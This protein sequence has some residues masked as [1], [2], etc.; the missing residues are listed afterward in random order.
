MQYNY[1]GKYSATTNY[2]KK[3]VVSYQTTTND[4]VKYYFCLTDHIN[5]LPTVSGD[6]AHWATVNTLSNFPNNVDTF[7]NHTNIQ[8]SDKSNVSRYQELILK[9]TLTSIE[10]D[11]LNTLTQTLRDK[12]ILPQDFNALQESI[13][14]MQMYLK[15][16]VEGYINQKQ[17]EMQSQIDKFTD[18]GDYSS[19]TTYQKNNFVTYNFET[20]IC[21]V[22]NTINILPTNPT[23]WRKAAARG[24]K[25]EKGDAGLNLVFK[26]SYDPLVSYVVGDAVEYQ[27]SVFYC[28][29]NITGETPSSNGTSWTIF[30]SR[31]S[32][33]VSNTAPTSP[34]DKQVWVDSSVGKFK[35]YDSATSSWKEVNKDDI[36]AINNKI[37]L[38]SGLETT[39]KSNLVGAT[40]EIKQTV[41]SHLADDVRHITAEERTEWDAKETPDGSRKKIEQTSYSK[42]KSNKDAE[43]IF[44]TVEYRRKSDNS[45]AIKAVLSGGT[46]PQYTTRTITYYALDG[47]TVEKTETF[48]LSYDAD[49]DYV[50][51][52]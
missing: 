43:G 45:L 17:A 38:L 33:A 12:L 16:S 42:S 9:T 19:T 30:M 51:E 48:S 21:T 4:P 1:K 26:N 31:A 49:G 15:D 52:V 41:M 28:K 47:T 24:L 25:G 46:S 14:N 13:S 2:V 34:T 10:Q 50:S 36:D 37:G 3:D 27:G 23:N 11:E 8:A 5:Q 44:T 20:Y 29:Q 7:L 22:D 18:K 32:I 40:N 35:W 6:N 39:D